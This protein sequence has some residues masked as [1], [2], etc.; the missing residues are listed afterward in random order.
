[1]SPHSEDQSPGTT[2]FAR[3]AHDTA[4]ATVA[5][6]VDSLRLKRGGPSRGA[7]GLSCRP[8]PSRVQFW[9]QRLSLLPAA[10]APSADPERLF[11]DHLP[12]IDRVV[13]VIARRHAM[14]ALDADEFASWA[15]ERII[16]SDYTVFRKFGGRSSMATYLT[17]VFGNLFHDYRNNL[18]GRWRPSA[19]ATR[20]G[21]IGTRLEE[22]LHRE[23][24]TLREACEVLRSSGATQSDVEIARM[25]AR[26]PA[27]SASTEVPLELVDGTVHEAYRPAPEAG[28]DDAGF[29][30]LRNAIRALT[31]EE[32]VILK[33]RF[34]DDVSVADIA[35]I[36]RIEQKPLYRRIES[37]ESRLR[38]LLTG[39]GLNRDRARDLLS[40][41]VVW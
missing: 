7:G 35:R 37:I 4:C 12:V 23:G 36:L 28:A 25:A 33:M 27:R 38:D 19:A 22:L 8:T 29:Q 13:A 18:W 34:W 10:G 3:V 21:A 17:V 16:G 40:S 41:E 14:S 11:L 39:R 32:Q 6:G 5:M 1:M 24:F 15:K 20:M 30:T 2:G 9:S 31:P 26:L